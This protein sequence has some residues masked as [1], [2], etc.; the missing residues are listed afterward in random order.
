[1]STTTTKYIPSKG[2]FYGGEQ[3]MDTGTV[4]RW[5]KQFKAHP[6]VLGGLKLLTPEKIARGDHTGY[7]PENQTFVS[8]NRNN[9]VSGGG[10]TLSDIY[11]PAPAPAPV[12][13]PVPVPV[14]APRTLSSIPLA[15]PP[16]YLPPQ[17][18]PQYT[19][20]ITTP[21]IEPRVINKP[22]FYRD[23]FEIRRY[24]DLDYNDLVKEIERARFKRK[25]EEL[26]EELKPKKKKSRSRKK[27]S[28]AKKKKSSS[29]KKRKKT[30]K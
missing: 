23:P 6:N 25:L 20:V 4:E 24:L 14:P 13:V 19:N 27:K 3:V 22:V 16:R 12:P 30:K 28:S 7:F 10:R 2:L 29:K 17:P 15:Q 9:L 5:S 8:L 1:M 18:L 21:R 26:E 11:R